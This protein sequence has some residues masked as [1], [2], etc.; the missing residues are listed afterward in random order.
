MVSESPADSARPTLADIT[1]RHTPRDGDLDAVRAITESAGFFTPAEVDVAV[2][3]VG[4]HLARGPASGYFF[5][6]AEWG[7]QVIGYTC[8]GPV[9]ATVESYDLYWIA[10]HARH[11]GL[12]LGRHLM[13]LAERAIREAGGR[14]VWVE[15][16]SR[17]LY[18]PTRAFYE[19]CGYA[20]VA[21]LPR[22]YA[23]DDNKVIF[24]KALA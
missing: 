22:Y 24:L 8:Y 2:E 5:C 1:F 9:P 7:G 19:R 12:G 23:P 18:V 16:S 6:F 20:I 11:R 15:T 13:D 14:Q 4:E 17:P 10:V 21:E 3:L